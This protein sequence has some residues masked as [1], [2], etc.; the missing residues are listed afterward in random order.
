MKQPSALCSVPQSFPLGWPL[1]HTYQNLTIVVMLLNF[2]VKSLLP[3]GRLLQY[4]C[5]RIYVFVIP[6]KPVF[7]HKIVH[8]KQVNPLYRIP[9][10]RPITNSSARAPQA[11]TITSQMSAQISTNPFQ[12]I[13]Q[14]PSS[15]HLGATSA[16]S[17]W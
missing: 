10:P 3:R 8:Q 17:Q 16:Q 1:K 4:P 13:L 7:L 9:H 11:V 5:K 2:T 6:Q 14:Q 12:A 15:S